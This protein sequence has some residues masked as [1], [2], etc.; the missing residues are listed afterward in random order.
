MKMTLLGVVGLVALGA[1]LLYLAK[2]LHEDYEEEETRAGY[3]APILHP[4]DTSTPEPTRGEP[5]FLTP[6]DLP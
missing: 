5:I 4:P 1:L 2:H 6:F 3:P